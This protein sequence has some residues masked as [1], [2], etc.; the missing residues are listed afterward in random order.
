MSTCPQCG[1][2]RHVA[3][4]LPPRNLPA[5]SR[6]DLT[7]LLTT[8]DP[9]DEPEIPYILDIIST[10]Q[11]R[12]TALDP[13]IRA[14]QTRLA[15][16][17][18][19]RDETA[20]HLR[21]HRALVSPLRRI[22]LELLCEIFVLSVDASDDVERAE[23]P[24]H[25][26]HI[27]QTWRRS[28]LAYPH[29][30]TDITIRDALAPIEAQLLRSGSAPLT[31][32]WSGIENTGNPGLADLII[33]HCGRWRRLKIHSH[34]LDDSDALEWLNR[35]KGHLDQLTTLEII[36]GAG[37]VIPDIFLAAPNLHCILLNDAEFAE[38]C[39]ALT[40][41]WAQ[42]THYRG[43]CMLQFFE[44]AQNLQVCS[45]GD[46]FDDDDLARSNSL[47]TLPWLRRLSIP[48]SRSVSRLKAPVLDELAFSYSWPQSLPSIISFLDRSCA[49]LTKLVLFYC[50]IGLE[51]IIFF[52]A[53]PAL[54]DLFLEDITTGSYQD[55]S[56]LFAAL[57]LSAT[58]SLCPRLTTLEYGYHAVPPSAVLD[59]FFAMTRS[60]FAQGHSSRLRRLCIFDVYESPPPDQII[61][62][63]ERLCEE[64]LDAAFFQGLEAQEL[65]LSHRF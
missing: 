13:E 60:R 44:A 50:T 4:E 40:L 25:L 2:S 21:R 6:P 64:G 38:S 45:F 19:E 59:S 41:P 63:V 23:V 10:A 54:T 12:I 16:L 46:G 61:L 5:E 14:L 42:L 27:C 36:D 20:E 11:D 24:W 31:V 33:P 39:P 62:Q 56:P 26:G 48:V 47:I 8:N 49:S 9:P 58:S 22:P 29:L 43:K 7:S 35:A 32:R 53:L 65:R 28:A 52:E 34:R 51:F 30:W 15:Q 1:A 37:A 3:A 57:T 55:H 18:R 17:V